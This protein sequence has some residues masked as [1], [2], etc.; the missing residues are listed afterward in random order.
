MTPSIKIDA[1][2]IRSVIVD[3]II[4]LISVVVV[5]FLI[6]FIIYPSIKNLPILYS[7]LKKKIST[8]IL[9]KNKMSILEKLVDFKTVVEEN[10]IILLSAIPSEP[11]VPQL[12]THVD[13]I[14]RESG[15]S[16]VSM[17]Y[18]LSSALTSE[19]GVTLAVSGN[20][21]QITNFLFNLERSSRVVDLDNFRYTESSDSLGN[22]SLLATFV[23]KS[24]YLAVNANAVTT[25]PLNLDITDKS[26][27][28]LLNEVK[29]LK[30]YKYSIEDL[31]F[32][33][34]PESSP[35]EDSL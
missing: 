13:Q 31:K 32:K 8:E 34:V 20:Y 19:V 24:P 6:L 16:V 12:L 25:E 14:A 3:F 7:D 5:L 4:P 26:F 23:L 17:N 30:I 9:L 2:K 33:N 18:T 10:S 22:K 29:K 15:L 11:Q 28:N 27:I 35:S 21:D 1:S